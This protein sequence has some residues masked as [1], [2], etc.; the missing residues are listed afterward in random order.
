LKPAE[1]FA[2]TGASCALA[3]RLIAP[4]EAL[5]PCALYG[6]QS[7]VAGVTRAL[8]GGPRALSWA[9]GR[10]RPWALVFGPFRPGQV[11]RPDAQ[12]QEWC[13]EEWCQPLLGRRGSAANAQNVQMKVKHVDELENHGSMH[14]ELGCPS[15]A[16]S[17]W[18]RFQA[19]ER[20]EG[21]AERTP[22]GP[23]PGGP[24]KQAAPT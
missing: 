22:V 15:I 1:P 6:G 17:V 11:S 21:I 23:E 24:A 7:A 16:V 20:R 8:A 14:R 3:V 12:D 2:L 4:T 9:T 10:P 13:Q 19:D 18:T 5:G